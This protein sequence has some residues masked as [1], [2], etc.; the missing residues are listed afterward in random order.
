MQ[1]GLPDERGAIL[2]SL[3]QLTYWT[4]SIDGY[5]NMRFAAFVSSKLALLAILL[6]LLLWVLTVL[7]LA[8]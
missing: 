6:L 4:K 1:T 2:A 3:V 7:P 5:A 8:S